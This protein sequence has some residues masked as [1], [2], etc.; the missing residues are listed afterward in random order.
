[1][2]LG[3]LPPEPL[4]L[5]TIRVLVGIP[6]MWAR[7]FAGVLAQYGEHIGTLI[8]VGSVVNLW[9]GH[10][11][12]VYSILPIAAAVLLLRYPAKWLEPRL[13]DLM[14]RIWPTRTHVTELPMSSISGP[15]YISGGLPV[16][17]D[18][19]DSIAVIGSTHAD[20][21]EE[22]QQILRL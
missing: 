17:Q 5:K 6:I 1:M 20:N 18:Q 9:R 4:W 16:V 8:V 21:V 13:E 22:H 3:K 12:R 19:P 11:E 15:E 14:Q 10:P 7:L 2:A